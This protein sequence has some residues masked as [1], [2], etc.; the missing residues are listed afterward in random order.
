MGEKPNIGAVP[1]LFPVEDRPASYSPLSRPPT[2]ADIMGRMVYA[3]SV[4]RDRS[5]EC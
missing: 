2:L 5:W 3:V 1:L 4:D